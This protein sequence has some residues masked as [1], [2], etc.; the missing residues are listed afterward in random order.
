[1]IAIDDL[2]RD[3]Q[4]WETLLA[5]SFLQRPHEVLLQAKATQDQ[6]EEMQMKNLTSAVS[7]SNLLRSVI[8]GDWR[9]N[10]IRARLQLAAS[11]RVING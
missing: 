3:L 6:I 10:S 8:L 11:E 9:L 4:H 7:S 5:S 1:M 2:V